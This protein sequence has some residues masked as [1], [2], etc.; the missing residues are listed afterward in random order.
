MASLLDLFV[1]IGA[2][3]EAT[4]TI[5]KVA[6]S[7]KT[8][9]KAIGVAVGTATTAVGTLTTSAVSAYADYE[10]LVGGI[11]TLF[12]AGGKSLEEYAAS[13]GQSTEEANAK[14]EALMRAQQAMMDNAS[15]AYETAGL[16]AN[17]YMETV[18]GFS[19]ALISSLG[20]DTVKAAEY[21]DMALTDM[22]DNANKMGTDM[23]SIQNAYQGFAKQNY[24]MLDNL[25]L[26]YGGTKEEMERLL[27][28]A[29]KIS[30]IEYDISS[31]ADIVDAIHVVQSEMGITGTTALEAATTVSG[32]ANRMKAAWKNWLTGLGNSKADM[33]DLTDKLFESMATWGDNVIPVVQQVLSSIVKVLEDNGTEM[34]GKAVQYIFSN[35][36]GLVNAATS[37]LIGLA[38]GI[39]KNLPVLFEAG[40]QIIDALQ[41][42]LNGADLGIDLQ[43]LIDTF[44]RLKPVIMAA[45]SALIAYK[46]AMGITNIISGV[47][48]AI[49]AFKTANE[50]TTI[51]QAALNAVMHANPFVLV[52]TIVAGLTAAVIT[53]WN[54]NEEFRNAT[55]EIWESIKAA[56]SSAWDSIRAVWETA[57]PYFQELWEHVK[58]SALELWESVKN[59]FSSA[60]E[61]IKVVWDFAQPYFQ[62]LWAAIQTVWA[63]VETW[64]PGLFETAWNLIIA[65]WDSA[66]GYFKRIFDSIALIFDAIKAVFQGDFQ[67]AWDAIKEIVGTWAD[68]FQNVWDNITGVFSDALNV[69][70]KIVSDIKTGISNKW[71]ELT[72]W[73]SNLWN[74]LFGG[75]TVDVGINAS[76]NVDDGMT[77]SHRVGSF[78]IG[79][80]Y[81][82]YNNY[83]ANLHRGEAVLTAPEANA[84]RK[85]YLGGYEK[86]TVVSIEIPVMLDGDKIGA[87][88]YQFALSENRRNGE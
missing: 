27:A 68:Y 57:Q 22:S 75:N 8:A 65:T 62:E 86:D 31:Y 67:G 39:V 82:P 83:L 49:K 2:K 61:A 37:L 9:F 36:P 28:D 1:K 48:T 4:G 76:A 18:T 71:N 47:I 60:W 55:A 16:S 69:G 13:A 59:A 70:E 87:A 6:S 10:Q 5:E 35:I 51:A 72:S 56:V 7:A 19:A 41:S 25:K 3:D 29:E 81:V 20:G 15:K 54:T 40:K 24:T 14:Y 77:S 17:E 30:G 38:N 42:A 45:V 32:S 34:I 80:D 53:L 44:A 26:G 58:A 79:L 66:T 50:A 84:Y 74:S 33:A 23:E 78:A 43:G 21:A 64:L 52:A 63:A 11:E 46:T 73:F 85:G 12:G 88:A